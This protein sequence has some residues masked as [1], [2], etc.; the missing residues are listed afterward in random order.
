ME[1]NVKRARTV[2][3]VLFGLTALFTF[4]ALFFNLYGSGKAGIN[5]FEAITTSGSG[6]GKFNRWLSVYSV[7]LIAFIVIEIVAYGV[8][9]AVKPSNMSIV[10]GIAIVLN[11]IL[12]FGYM[13]NGCISKDLNTTFYIK[14]VT[15]A[16]IPTII[17]SIF[18]LA[19]FLVDLFLKENYTAQKRTVE[20]LIFALTVL[21]AISSLAFVFCETRIEYKGEYYRY[22]TFI[23][24]SGF[25]I[26]DKKTTFFGKFEN[27]FR[28]YSCIVIAIVLIELVVYGIMW[29]GKAREPRKVEQ[30]FI[31]TN[32]V[33]VLVYMINGIIAVDIIKGS[34]YT[35]IAKPTTYAFVPLIIMSILAVVYF[36]VANRRTYGNRKLEK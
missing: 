14:E 6:L 34:D 2:S 13:L 21:I 35:I 20:V 17:V 15:E 31:L 11:V 36:I 19:Y 9:I 10:E 27:W 12:V 5:G 16:F 18:A 3:I 32:F 22:E 4:L 7:V 33:L 26:F 30:W 1:S 29:A 23:R 25:L 28:A 8:V 24:E